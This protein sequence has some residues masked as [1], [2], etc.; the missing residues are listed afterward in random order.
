MKKSTL[1]IS[2][3]LLIFLSP[4][5][6]PQ[7]PG[8]VNYGEESGLNNSYTYNLSQDH[9]GFIWVGSDNGFFRFDGK[10]FIQYSKKSGLK[11]LEILSSLPLD[12]GE[13]FIFPFL[14]DFAYLKNGHIINSD[15]NKEL[16][17]IQFKYNANYS[18]DHQSV[19][20]FTSYN[21]ENIYVFKDEKVTTI[22]LHFNTHNSS[23]IYYALTLDSATHLLYLSNKNNSKEN[24]LA[25]DIFTGKKTTCNI[26]L[27]KE[28]T[29]YRKDDFFIFKEKRKITIYQLCNK[30]IFKKIQTYSVKENIHQVIV[31]K[32]YRIWLCIEEGG[33]LYFRET[34][35]DHK[36]LTTPIPFLSGNIINHLMVDRDNNTW[37]ST[38][39]NGVYFITEK[40]L[41][42]YVHLPVR[43]NSAYI[44]AISK[45]DNN[46]LLGYNESKAGIYN[47]H[48]IRDLVFEENR[49]IE[50]KAIVSDSNMVFFGLSRSLVQYNMATGQKQILGDFNLKSIVPYTN[51]SILICS[52][53][54][55]TSYHYPSRQYT[56][57]IRQ[58]RVYTALPY[59]KDSLFAGSFK[60][61]Y[62]FNTKT[63]EKKLFLE[64][65]Y[66][67]DLKKLSSTVYVGTTN[68][69][70][71]IIF[72]NHKILHKLSENTGLPTNQIKKIEVENEKAFWASTNSGL[73]RVEIT[74]S[75]FRINN[76]TQPDGLP[77]NLVAGCVIK[78]DTIY[79]G[80]SKGL[81]ILSV[82]DLLMQQKLIE[83]KAIINSVM[84]GHK[85]FFNVNQKFISQAPEN[86][87]MFN[88]SFPDYVSQGKIRYKYKV[89]GLGESWLI[90]SSPKIILNSVPPGEYILK[91]F[92][93]GYN[94]RQA[95]IP[96]EM[97]FEIKPQFWQTWWFRTLLIVGGTALLFI[98]INWYFQKKRNKKLETL[99]YEKKI[100]EL[101]LQAIKA[102]INPHFIY[103]CLNSIQFLLYKKDYEETENYLNI[104]SQMIRKTL[105][106]SEK[107]FM[108][109]KEEVEYLSLYLNM[110]KL[111]LKEQFEYTIKVS[112]TVNE[113]WVIPSLLI[114]PFVEN[115][116]KHGIASITDRKGKIG[117]FFDYINA[118]LCITIEDN[119]VGINSVNQSITKT[120]SFGVRLSQKRIETFKQLFETHIT[121][122]IKSFPEQES[123]H[124]TQ[125]KLYITPYEN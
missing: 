72:T 25:Y 12:N 14:N 34:L 54:G 74:G 111:R 119:G 33:A 3:L 28:V 79:V 93:L 102:Q 71:I 32:N 9:N 112:E 17:K 23:D 8:L 26:P 77:S 81:G 2:F 115:A 46:I 48:A 89:E 80:T 38:R 124:G 18:Y 94:G 65:Y 57:M 85:E 110:E 96:T 24:I 31:D 108:P 15:S 27:G 41:K 82:K 88:L 39:N 6:F 83:K 51:N 104:F 95:T 66:F 55:L 11:N 42:S 117:I 98:L 73:S 100:A 99:Y 61:L 101:E 64:D 69:N 91:V 29:L 7:I 43:N 86:D 63:K 10:E 19:Y 78:N 21:P 30:F 35:K 67:T 16:R 109:V 53:E 36:K 90:S 60:D 45:N 121:L 56:E 49:K 44:T 105:Y 87:I 47:S 70:G 97:Y 107:T 103:N 59:D 40:F 106:Y 118:S 125:I 120:G 4:F 75:R 1:F 116:I 5:F 58:E 62:K 113:N 13:V 76:F 20:I 68:R 114:Q 84:I 122:E 52:S 92:G 22:P 123:K 50:H 37:F